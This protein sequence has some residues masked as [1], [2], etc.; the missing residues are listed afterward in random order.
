VASPTRGLDVS[1]IEFVR[2]LLDEHRRAGA[3]IVLISED[4]DEI[5]GLADR[6]VV[7][8]AGRLVLETSVASCDVTELGLAMAGAVDAGP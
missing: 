7:M 2:R 3:A 4:L 6:I 5:F 1:G 8:Y